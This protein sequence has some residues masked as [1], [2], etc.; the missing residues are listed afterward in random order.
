MKKIC[1]AILLS[2]LIVLS[3]G[4][5]VFA[6]DYIDGGV[7]K[8]SSAPL[9]TNTVT[10]INTYDRTVGNPMYFRLIPAM[11]DFYTIETTGTVDTEG[12]LYDA[13]GASLEVD[14]DDAVGSNFQINRELTGGETYYLRVTYCRDRW[15]SDNASYYR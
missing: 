13:S 10:Y 4:I 2:F 9:L 6:E 14:D 8:D 11:T 15:R 7:Y 3:G 12:E 1:F 5:L